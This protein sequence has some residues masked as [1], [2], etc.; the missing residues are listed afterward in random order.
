M[1]TASP[2]TAGRRSGRRGSRPAGPSPGSRNSA[3]PA[4]RRT[5]RRS[6]PGGRRAPARGRRRSGRRRRAEVTATPGL[7]RWK[8]QPAG[9]GRGGPASVGDDD[10]GGVRKSWRG[11]ER[12]L[13]VER[14]AEPEVRAVLARR[15]SAG[16]RAS[17]RRGGGGG[18]GRRRA[19][20]CRCAA[21]RDVDGVGRLGPLG[22]RSARPRA[23]R[24]AGASSSGSGHAQRQ[25]RLCDHG[26]AAASA[27]EP[28]GVEVLDLD[29]QL[30]DRPAGPEPEPLAERGQA[31]VVGA[32]QVAPAR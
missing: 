8:S 16:C 11:L 27:R 29:V 1:R 9:P 31:G 24:S 30:E 3:E 4:P 15:R 10:R 28:V 7:S 13:Q 2:S 26:S 18:P 22:R 5:G 23:G 14:H 32:D 21:G 25:A 20:P 19:G 6:R 17:G 12:L